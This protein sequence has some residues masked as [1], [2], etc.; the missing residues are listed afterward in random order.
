MRHSSSL[1]L[2]GNTTPAQQFGRI[3][4]TIPAPHRLALTSSESSN[5]ASL[6]A[7]AEVDEA[8]AVA[9]RTLGASGFGDAALEPGVSTDAAD[10]AALQAA[11]REHRARRLGEIAAE[12]LRAAMARVLGWRARY[13]RR[14][15][16]QAI[17]RELAGLDSRTLRDL[18]IHHR[19]ELRF[20]ASRL[21]HGED[22]RERR[23]QR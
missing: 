7:R 13:R 11:A 23:G 5:A 2:L 4:R 19:S 8:G 22:L 21:A 9:R 17:H 14:V 1:H 20:I 3:A 12:L 6:A 18:G 16:A 15:D 10:S